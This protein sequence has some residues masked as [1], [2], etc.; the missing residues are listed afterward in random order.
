M[1]GTFKI[2]HIRFKTQQV[3]TQVANLP[4]DHWR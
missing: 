4:K 2:Q 3:E 1:E